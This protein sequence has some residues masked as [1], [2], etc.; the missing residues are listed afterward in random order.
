MMQNLTDVG[1]MYC[2]LETAF[3]QSRHYP[4]VNTNIEL[5]VQLY[6]TSYTGSM[7]TN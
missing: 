7:H 5:V 6:L 2:M 3:K 1:L 4:S